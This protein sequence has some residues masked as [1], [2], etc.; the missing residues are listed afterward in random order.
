MFFED[1]SETW[2]GGMEGIKQKYLSLLSQ[3]ERPGLDHFITWLVNTDF[4]EAPA[5]ANG[6][7]N[8]A[9]GLAEHS[10]T[11]YHNLVSLIMVTDAEVIR[12]IP[13]NLDS[14][15][16]TSLCHDICKADFYKGSFK[17][18]K[19]IDTEGKECLND[20]NK[21]IWDTVPYFTISDQFPIGHGE[22]SVII[23]QKFIALKDMEIAAIRWHMGGFDDT[24]RSYAGGLA[25]SGAMAKYP[26]VAFLHCA[27]L[28]ASI[29][30]IENAL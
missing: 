30:E 28:I 20:K 5:S 1:K 18:Q 16:I 12:A 17:Q 21:P 22:K 25:A 11:V 2:L 26:L 6:H 19:R 29:P 14:V 8:Y 4:F 27:D 3:V 7:N 13:M 24:A 15:I 23:L 10:L 9:G